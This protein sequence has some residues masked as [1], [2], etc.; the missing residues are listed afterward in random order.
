MVKLLVLTTI[1][2]AVLVVNAQAENL[3]H[4]N[5]RN[6]QQQ[7]Q[8]M[9]SL[10]YSTAPINQSVIQPPQYLPSLEPRILP[11][12]EIAKPRPPIMIEPEVGVAVEQ[13]IEP[14]KSIANLSPKT[15][16]IINEIG[17]GIGSDKTAP[18]KI[19]IE[20]GGFEKKEDIGA[21][22]NLATDGFQDVAV[23]EAAPS[24]DIEVSENK[25]PAFSDFETLKKAKKALDVGQYES[26]IVLYQS[27]LNKTPTNLDA[28]FGLAIS[29]QKAGRKNRAK[30][31][32]K[33]IIDKNPTYEP[34]LNNLLALAATEAPE[35]ALEEFAIIEGRNPNFAGVYAQ[36]AKIYREQLNL[37]YAITNLRR[38]LSLEPENNNYRYDLAIIED[39]NGDYAAAAQLYAELVKSANEGKKIPADKDLIVDRMNYISSL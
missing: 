12:T 6:V 7:I 39:E 10:G 14:S 9:P 4:N 29:Y 1:F 33:Q 11:N 20:A 38:A 16:N 5:I 37:E 2:A 26:A 18:E 32:Y 28:M 36:K 13:I 21:D 34:A 35:R 30:D 22:D 3:R 15:Q 25:E 23:V 31:I 8:T 19:V 24:F 17:S 27:V